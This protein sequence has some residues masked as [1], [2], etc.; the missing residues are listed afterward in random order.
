MGFLTNRVGSQLLE[1]I[2]KLKGKK[3]SLDVET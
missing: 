2:A 1:L 3:K